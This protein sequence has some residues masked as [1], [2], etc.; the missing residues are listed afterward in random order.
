[1]WKLKDRHWHGRQRAAGHDLVVAGVNTV[2]SPPAFSRLVVPSSSFSRCC[3]LCVRFIVR[4]R[5][6]HA[7]SS[8]IAI[9]MA[10]PDE[11]LD[12]IESRFV[13][14]ADETEWVPLSLTLVEY[15]QGRYERM[16]T[17]SSLAVES[18]P[19]FYL[20]SP[21][22]GRKPGRYRIALHNIPLLRLHGGAVAKFLLIS[23]NYIQIT[24]V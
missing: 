5:A 19:S 17:L 6:R 21:R 11:P 23:F 16:A 13:R 7:T 14:A 9:T 2:L 4:R 8:R 22:R 10:S 20:A 18:D 12:R 24:F 15:P 3:T 1:M